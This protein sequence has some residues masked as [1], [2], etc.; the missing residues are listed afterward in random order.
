M[1]GR[2]E[3]LAKEPPR[4]RRLNR[5]R[6]FRPRR[7]TPTRV[8]RLVAAALDSAVRGSL[9]DPFEKSRGRLVLSESAWDLTASCTLLTSLASVLERQAHAHSRADLAKELEE[10]RWRVEDYLAGVRAGE[11]V[12]VAPKTSEED[13]AD[14]GLDSDSLASLL[15]D[16][17]R[18]ER[19]R[20]LEEEE[21]RYEAQMHSSV[22]VVSRLNL[23][24][25]EPEE[26]ARL[27]R[28]LLREGSTPAERRAQRAQRLH[29]RPERP[30][31]VLEVGSTSDEAERLQQRLQAL[32]SEQGHPDVIWTD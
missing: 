1:D 19:Q 27:R 3:A 32:L 31:E 20:H 2:E 28:N 29:E 5:Q 9:Y 26:T 10:Y 14:W 24:G 22:D 4:V 17:S 30:G 12:L 7:F 25:V 15:S 18:A 11:V 13:L 21:Q 8:E 23:E 16:D 6:P